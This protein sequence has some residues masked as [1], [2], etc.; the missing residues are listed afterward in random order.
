MKTIS[1]K[2]LLKNLSGNNYMRK[3]ALKALENG[4]EKNLVEESEPKLKKINEKKYQWITA[5]LADVDYNMRKGRISKH[6]FNRLVDTI[7]DGAF[8]VDKASYDATVTQFKQKH[9]V[10]PPSFLVI[11]PTQRCNLSCTGCYASSNKSTSPRLDFK[12]F[13]RLL[14]EFHDEADGRFVVVSGGEPLM[15]KDSGYHLLDIFEKYSDVFF[16]FYTNGTII[17][18]KVANRLA[19]L[20]NAIPAISVEG[21]RKETDERRG[22]GVFDK[23]LQSMQNLRE[24][25]V[26]FCISATA[27]EKNADILLDDYFYDFFFKEQGASYMWQFQLMPI[28]RG[29]DIFNLMPSPETRVKLFRKWEYLLKEKQYAVVD[30]WNSGVLTHGCIAYGRTHG[31]A[32]I[33]WNGNIMPCVFVPYSEDN[34]YDIYARG[35][36]FAD[37]LKSDLF[38]RGKAWQRSYKPEGNEVPK[39]LLMPCSIRDH[40]ANFRKNILTSQTKGEDQISEEILKDDQYYQNLVEYDK[41]LHEL[42]DPIWE[43]EYLTEILKK[44]T[45]EQ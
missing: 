44:Q 33:D 4:I 13:D 10:E 8:H 42:T 32:Y 3:A 18:K 43:N 11:S 28:G 35:G 25:G 12:T 5:M 40:Y 45:Q 1:Y 15:Y 20:G 16:M 26:T 9:G 29:N 24:A 34:I 36:S 38:M 27:T 31:Y 7:V 41:R 6:A 23:I 39:N 17:S 37:A 30:F 21:F 19:E 14:Q 2:Q 22:E